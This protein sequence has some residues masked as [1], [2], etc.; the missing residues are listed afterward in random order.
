LQAAGI[1]VIFKTHG[2]PMPYLK[3]IRRAFVSYSRQDHGFVDTLA[4]DLRKQAFELWVDFEGLEPGTPDWEAAVRDAIKKSFAVLLIASPNSR[5]SSY[6][7]SELL[8][9]QAR[10]LPIYALWARGKSW[11]DSIPMNLAHM[12]YLDFRDNAYADSL[13]LLLEKLSGFDAAIPKHFIYKSFYYKVRPGCPKPKQRTR[14]FRVGGNDHSFVGFA[15]ELIPGAMEIQ[16]EDIPRAVEERGSVDTLFVRPDAFKTA[17]HLLDEIYINYLTE[18][19]PPFSFGSQWHLRRKGFLIQL[20]I[21]WRILYDHLEAEHSSITLMN[22]S[23]KTYWLVANSD[24][25]IAD[26]M[27][28]HTTVLAVYE[29][30]LS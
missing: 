26:G 17:A 8:L 27:P 24:W 21:D 18:R 28:A 5:K 1:W 7:R 25:E 19:Y 22:G 4:S 2:L 23:P 6:V 9:A 20:A 30:W 16:L 12:Q 10:K 15:K 29:R 14:K 13:R 3:T 11:I